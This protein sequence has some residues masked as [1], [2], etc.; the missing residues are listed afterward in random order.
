[1]RVRRL[2]LIVTVLFGMLAPAA[3]SID[4]AVFRLIRNNAKIRKIV[5][6]GNHYFSAPEIK[7]HLYSKERNFFS[8]LNS[9]RRQYLLVRDKQ[10]AY[11][12]AQAES[13]E[14]I[15]RQA[16]LEDVFIKLTGER[17]ST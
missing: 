3:K 6:E 4:R 2:F 8:T 10:E 5:I 1:M 17:L 16:N 14:V 11:A 13:A 15:I 7:D 9:G 12:R